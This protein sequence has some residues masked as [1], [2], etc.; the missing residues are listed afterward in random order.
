MTN[1]SLTA[2]QAMVSTPLALIS[3]AWALKPGTCLTEQVGVKAP[4][5]ANRATVLPLKISSVVIGR[6][7][8]GPQVVKVALGILS[9]I[10]TVMV[11]LSGRFSDRKSTRLNSSH[12]AI[13]YAVFCLKKKKRK[14]K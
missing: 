13:S 5:T 10:L 11:Y 6:G 2:T 8:S 1:T 14:Q 3:A 12:V 9:P 4:G 7:P